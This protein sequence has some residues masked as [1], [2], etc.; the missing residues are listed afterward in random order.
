VVFASAARAAGAVAA[1]QRALA[2]EEWPE[3]MP[4]RLRMGLHTGEAKLVGGDYIGLEVHRAARIGAAG[5]GGQIL[6][7]EPT[8]T[9][10]EKDLPQGT[11][12]RDLGEHRLKDLPRPERIFQLDV[13]GLPSEFPALKSLNVR[14]NNLPLQLT[15]FVG[16]EQELTELKGLLAHERLVTLVGS[17]G[18]GKTRLSNRARRRGPGGV[19]AGCV[20]GRA[21]THPGRPGPPERRKLDYYNRDRPHRS[22]GLE[23][24]LPSNVRARG[25]V[26]PRPVLGGDI[27]VDQFPP[28]V[29]YAKEDVEGS[30][31]A[32]ARRRPSVV[33][34][35]FL[36]RYERGV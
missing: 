3:G 30:E 31:V 27:D 16:R 29:A 2:I 34:T 36:G 24:P 17:G 21:H 22:L 14:R 1:A 9:L 11:S 13:E 28:P 32:S 19:R 4:V 12:L 18:V 20:A 8:S 6:I 10:I 35:D 26:V 7:S 25:R 23:S 33:A 15:S 5:H